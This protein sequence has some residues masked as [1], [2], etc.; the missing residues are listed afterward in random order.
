M[1]DDNQI[2]ISAHASCIYYRS[3]VGRKYIVACAAAQIDTFM[4]SAPA[5]FEFGRYRIGPIIRRPDIRTRT[6]CW[7]SFLCSYTDDLFYRFFFD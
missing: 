5:P 4:L 6:N 7:W 2:S 3:A 1:I